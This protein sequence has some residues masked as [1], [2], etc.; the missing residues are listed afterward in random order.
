MEIRLGTLDSG[1]ISCQGV[2]IARQG[3][4]FLLVAWF[5]W[6]F[7]GPSL[8][9]PITWG[10]AFFLRLGP[11]KG[12]GAPGAADTVPGVHEAPIAS[13]RALGMGVDGSK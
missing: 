6:G 7:L 3:I 2:P 8:V 11:G 1:V 10:W 4:P 9:S 5:L 13:R 12:R